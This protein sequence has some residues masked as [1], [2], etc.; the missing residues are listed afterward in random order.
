MRDATLG[1]K[2]L[3]RLIG[4]SEKPTGKKLPLANHF[5]GFHGPH[6]GQLGM[7]SQRVPPQ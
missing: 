4:Q 3:T 2:L 1:V 5:R 6:A 7:S